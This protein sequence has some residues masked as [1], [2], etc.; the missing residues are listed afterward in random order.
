MRKDRRNRLSHRAALP[1]PKGGVDASE[2]ADQGVGR[3]PG[4]PP[5]QIV[6]V[7]HGKHLACWDC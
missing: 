7:I 3:G 1:Q 2:Q 4:G 5:H 6:D